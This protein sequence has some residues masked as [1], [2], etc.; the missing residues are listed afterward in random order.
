MIVKIVTAQT[1]DNTPQGRIRLPGKKQTH[2]D[3]NPRLSIFCSWPKP[4]LK[5]HVHK[6]QFARRWLVGYP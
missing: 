5:E 2:R 4:P 3:Q 1:V 6:S